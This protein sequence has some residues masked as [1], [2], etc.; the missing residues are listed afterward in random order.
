[1]S[2]PGFFCDSAKLSVKIDAQQPTAWPVKENVKIDGLDAAAT[3]R[4]VVFCNGKPQQSF[5]FRFSD[6]K[7]RVL[8]LFINDMYKTAQLWESK[9]SSWCKCK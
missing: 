4:V 8:C 7:T 3:H 5:R 2:A 1:M 9:G 6:L